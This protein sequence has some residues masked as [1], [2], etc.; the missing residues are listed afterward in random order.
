[1]C[2]KECERVF[3]GVSGCQLLS[4]GVKCVCF[5]HC[6]CERVKAWV[7]EVWRFTRVPSAGL[8]RGV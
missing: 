7:C 8:L 4:E 5:S 6:T 2:E 3:G 1:M